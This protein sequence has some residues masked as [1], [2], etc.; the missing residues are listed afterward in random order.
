VDVVGRLELKGSGA[1]NLEYHDI[2]NPTLVRLLV[3]DG[4]SAQTRSIR[5]PLTAED[6]RKTAVS[7]Q[8]QLGSQRPLANGVAS[9]FEKLGNDSHP[10]GL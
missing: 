10:G 6:M 1:G 5:T 2:V 3:R 7:S 9:A 8:F 4:R